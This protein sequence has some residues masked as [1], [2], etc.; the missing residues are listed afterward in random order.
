MKSEKFNNELEYI[1]D[2][3]IKESCKIMLELLPDYFYEIPAS[4][5]GKYHPE[6]TL[7]DRGLV[8]HTKM[9]TRI[10]YE[11]LNNPCIGSKYTQEEQ[12]LMIM[13]MILHDG[14]KSGIQ[15]N[16]YTQVDHPIL[17]ANYIKDNKDKLKLTD[18][19]ITFIMDA[20]KTHMGPW[21][22]DFKGNVVLEVPKTKY[23]NFV[24]MCDYLAS[25]KFLLTKFDEFDNIV[26]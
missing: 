5:T 22:T 24:H 17:I 9:V 19:Q 3:N 16:K 26:E 6:Y 11:L 4:S 21:N 8:R 12:D 23:Q 14:L 10:G 18:N 13:G 20:I 7:G 25:R 15:K 1:K 2:Y